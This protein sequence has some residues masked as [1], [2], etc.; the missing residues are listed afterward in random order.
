MAKR[1]D[2]DLL[3]IKQEIKSAQ[4]GARFSGRAARMLFYGVSA[5]VITK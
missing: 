5:L 4:Q 3:T 2:F 1:D